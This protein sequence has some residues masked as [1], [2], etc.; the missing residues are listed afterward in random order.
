MKVTDQTLHG[1]RLKELAD[2][3]DLNGK[4]VQVTMYEGEIVLTVDSTRVNA[5]RAV[6]DP[7]DAELLIYLLHTNARKA[8]EWIKNHG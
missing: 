5:P 2:L 1:K 7:A 4:G 8:R 6:L 3:L